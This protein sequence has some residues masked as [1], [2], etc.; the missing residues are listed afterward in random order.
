MN[1][2]S[3]LHI[4][5]VKIKCCF[6]HI[7]TISLMSKMKVSTHNKR[8]FKQQLM[9]KLYVKFSKLKLLFQLLILLRK[10]CSSNRYKGL[11][12]PIS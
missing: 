6:F 5:I 2:F 10:T 3:C 7:L 11:P 4:I 1:N 12:K 8:S 9:I